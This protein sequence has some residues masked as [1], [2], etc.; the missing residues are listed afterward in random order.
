MVLAPAVGAAIDGVATIVA[1][2]T[3]EAARPTAGDAAELAVAPARGSVPS[4]VITAGGGGAATRPAHTP[5]V[6]PATLR[7]TSLATG[8]T[9]PLDEGGRGRNDIA[10]RGARTATVTSP[11]NCAAA[12]GT[13]Q[14][15]H[16]TLRRPSCAVG[17]EVLASAV[18]AGTSAVALAASN[19]GALAAANFAPCYRGAATA[20]ATLL[21][22]CRRSRGR[23]VCGTSAGPRG[24]TSATRATDATSGVAVQGAGAGPPGARCSGGVQPAGTH[25]RP[26]TPP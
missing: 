17:A 20:S 19:A 22:G 2:R 11:P 26:I 10:R 24:G 4:V 3:A 12:R 7:G 15:P 8:A 14:T 6:R 21:A 9:S 16:A 23:R 1:I 5:A 25:G 13:A 18:P